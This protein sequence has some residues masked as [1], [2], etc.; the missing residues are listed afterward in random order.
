[1]ARGHT[2]RATCLPCCNPSLSSSR[3]AK[4][5]NPRY[6]H[7]DLA[8][9]GKVIPQLSEILAIASLRAGGPRQQAAKS[10]KRGIDLLKKHASLLPVVLTSTR[11]CPWLHRSV[12]LPAKKR[13]LALLPPTARAV[14]ANPPPLHHVSGQPRLVPMHARMARGLIADVLAARWLPYSR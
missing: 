7:R 6:R 1:M 2:H 4:R 10:V 13:N 11:L 9:A 14:P 5:P 8:T 3:V 12:V